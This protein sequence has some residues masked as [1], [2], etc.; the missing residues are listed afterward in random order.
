MLVLAN[1]AFKSGSTWLYYAVG[2]LTGFPP[3]PDEFRNPRWLNSSI[4]PEKLAD[5]LAR[6]D[7]HAGDYMTKTHFGKPEQRDLILS[8]DDVYVLNIKRDMRDVVVSAYYHECRN[9]GYE[10]SFQDFYGERGR[11]VAQKVADYHEVWSLESSRVHTSSFERML[12]DGA[13][14]LRRIGSFLGIHTT[15]G[16]IGEILKVLQIDHI[17]KAT[18]QEHD[19]IPFFRKGVAGDWKN[20]FTAEMIEDFEEWC[21]N[22]RQGQR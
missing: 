6:L 5:V 18:G 17:R 3:P 8:Y 10:G 13:D 1:G 22:S 19:Q 14:E 16:G 12:E 20:H 11:E 15:D 2:R 7:Y 21:L 9:A 4:D